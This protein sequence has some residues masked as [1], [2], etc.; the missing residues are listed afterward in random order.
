MSAMMGGIQGLQM[1]KYNAQVAENEATGAAQDSVAAQARVSSDARA[2]AGEA[3]AAQGASGLQL[4]TGS[5]LDVLRENATNAALD[6]LTI[7]ARGANAVTSAK[8]AAQLS[9]Y[10][11]RSAFVGGLLKTGEQIAAYAGGAGGG[12]SSKFVAPKLDWTAIGKASGAG[13][14]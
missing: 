4:G 12:G 1:G 10:Q 7:R 3:I 6:T 8:S 13:G 9:K 14:G 2:A 5:M 11:G